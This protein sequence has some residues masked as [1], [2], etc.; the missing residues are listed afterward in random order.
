MAAF[1]GPDGT[2]VLVRNH[3]LFTIPEA[4]GPFGERNDLLSLVDR[5]RVYDFGFG[6]PALGG[7]TTLVY[8]TRDQRVVRQFLSL[9]GTTRNCAGGA[10]PW[11]SWITCEEFVIGANEAHEVPHGFNFEVPARADGGLVV[12][13][14]LV[15][16]G[17]F[18]HE[19]VA[20][21]PAS[22]AFYQTEDRRDGILY[23]FLP[24]EPGN[25]AAG[26]RLQ[27][28]VVRDRPG[29][30]ARNWEGPTVAVGERLAVR[31]VDLE[32]PESPGDDLRRQGASL[33]AAV[34]SRGEGM[35]TGTD[36]IYFA[37]T[38]G[39]RRLPDLLDGAGQIWRYVPSPAEG[40]PDEEAEPGTLELLYEP[41]DQ[42]VLD[43]CDNVVV[44][45][46]GDLL[47]CEDGDGDLDYLLGL[48]PSGVAYR[49]ARNV[50][51]QSEFA[52]ATFSPD[53]TTLFVNYQ[54]SGKTFAI[55][56]PWPGRRG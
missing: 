18:N 27:A 29:L 1:P 41:N 42:S 6:T 55:T 44:A 36:G 31:W 17:R 28:L 12:P 30:D 20:I 45:P 33:G 10:T 26:G 39:G 14:P 7:T 19:A 2:T 15:A 3:E 11:G 24:Q 5:S 35:A 46:W 37:C 52:G 56:G 43:Q 23:R 51:D 34:F 38:S 13:V 9:V 47:I 49:I 16:M 8:D 21:D 25:L 48:R 40:T 53:G 32:Q 54:W 22:G 4:T 50:V